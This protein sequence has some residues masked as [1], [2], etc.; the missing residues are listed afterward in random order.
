MN[1]KGLFGEI[2]GLVL[3]FFIGTFFG[4]RI[5]DLIKGWLFK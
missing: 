4:Q 3:G 5:I 1:K 2:F